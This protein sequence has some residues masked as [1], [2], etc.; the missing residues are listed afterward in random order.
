[1]KILS[2]EALPLCVPMPYGSVSGVAYYEKGDSLYPQAVASEFSCEPVCNLV[3]RGEV[4][5][6][7]VAFSQA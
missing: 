1:M 7:Q 3:V 5:E 2:E 6:S 4:V